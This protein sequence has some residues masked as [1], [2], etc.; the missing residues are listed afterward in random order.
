[1]QRQLKTELGTRSDNT[2]GKGDA[3]SDSYLANSHQQQMRT[4]KRETREQEFLRQEDERRLIEQAE[5]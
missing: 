3:E 4:S 5:D 2:D 1:M